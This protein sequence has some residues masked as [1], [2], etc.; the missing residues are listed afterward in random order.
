MR[1]YEAVDVMDLES[2]QLA[3]VCPPPHTHTAR[4]SQHALD[5][6]R[7]CAIVSRGSACGGR[8][9]RAQEEQTIHA[10]GVTCVAW[11]PCLFD[12]PELVVGTGQADQPMVKVRA[13][14]GTRP[15]LGS[16]AVSGLCCRQFNR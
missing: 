5:A 3:G 1:M 15:T 16:G 9:E 7:E 8:M 11:N 2:W 10:P 4:P 14:T 12:P 6:R 13:R